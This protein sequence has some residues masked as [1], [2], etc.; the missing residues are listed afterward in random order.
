M[1][2]SDQIE[3]LEGVLESINTIAAQS[4]AMS[5]AFGRVDPLLASMFSVT[6]TDADALIETVDDHIARLKHQKQM[7]LD[8]VFRS[9]VVV[10]DAD[11]TPD[12]DDQW[13]VDQARLGEDLRFRVIGGPT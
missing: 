11:S 1:T 9:L 5:R 7:L 3:A 13:E 6:A 10:S 4:K 2:Y 8:E 12:W